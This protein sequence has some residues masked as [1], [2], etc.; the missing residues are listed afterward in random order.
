MRQDPQGEGRLHDSIRESD[1]QSGCSVVFAAAFFFLAA[2]YLTHESCYIRF[3]LLALTGIVWHSRPRL[4][5]ICS[6]SGF[7]RVQNRQFL[8]FALIIS[9]SRV[10]PKLRLLLIRFTLCETPSRIAA[11]CLQVA[12]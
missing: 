6:F 5:I 10:V 9:K 7:S 2:M 11:P 1:K 8:I 12:C 3:I 4:C